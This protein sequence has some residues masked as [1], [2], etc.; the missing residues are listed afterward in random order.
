MAGRWSQ[1]SE[2]F[3]Y[4][5]LHEKRFQELCNALL[6]RENPSVT[7]FPVGQR[8]GGRDAVLAKGA[9]PDVIYQVKWAKQPP[10][11]PVGWLIAA[12]RGESANIERLV[13][14]G[15]RSYV[16]MTC[17]PGTAAP[18]SGSM[19]RLDLE[20]ARCSEQFGIP[21][22]CL[23]R[24]DIDARVE[25]APNELVW[26]YAEMLAGHEAVRYVIEA[27]KITGEDQKLRR[28]LLN[29]I[30]TQWEEDAKIKFR[31]VELDTYNLSD[32]YVDVEAVRTVA[33]RS[34]GSEVP[35]ML[36]RPKDVVSLGGAAEYLLSPEHPLTLV[37]GEPGQGKSTLAQ[38]LCQLHRAS[39]LRDGSY[40]AG[41]GEIPRVESP[42]LPLRVD[43]RDYAR[44]CGGE[45][46]F[47]EDEPVPSRRRR[48]RQHPTL[49]KFLAYLLTARG[50]G[51]EVGVEVVSDVLERFPMLIVLDGLDEVAH[52]ETRAHVSKEIGL[53]AARLN[54]SANV[55]QVIVTTR[56]NASGLAEPSPERFETI[57]LVPLSPALR[58]EYLRKWADARGLRGA[59]RRAVET[60]FQQR[61]IEPHI[62][63]LADNPMQLTILLYL[64]QK[65]GESVPDGRTQLFTA[66]MET[67]LDRESE[68][69]PLV[70]EHR[71]D[72]VEVT[73]FLG[74]H[75]QASAEID[76]SAGRASTRAIRKAILTYLHDAEKDTALVDDLFTAVT[77][78]VW[79]LSSKVQG[80]FE[81]DVQTMREYFAA[82]YLWGF[83]G[84]DLRN[85]DKSAILGELV[86]RPYWLNTARFFAG[87]A[88]PNELAGLVDVLADE[89]EKVDRPNQVR[90][91]AWTLL[92]DG[93]FDRQTRAHK[94]AARLFTDDL[95]VRLM[96]NG[97]QWAARTAWTGT[98]GS[99]RDRGPDH[100]IALLEE[101]I[102]RA[103]DEPMNRDRIGLIQ[104]LGGDPTSWWPREMSASVG[105]DLELAWLRCGAPLG[106]GGQ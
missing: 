54:V 4:E 23:W 15:A 12:I 71:E 34:A 10:Q 28:I 92:S 87:F 88:H 22:R 65:R 33:A 93:V 103:P 51:A 27:D 57:A 3:L 62:A 47:A 97:L 99:T 13:S 98:E 7:C 70:H 69:S 20:L 26:S 50:A 85:F 89:F 14:E 105:S 64:I 77:D 2:R 90:A 59:A 8:D 63:Q 53:L 79:A 102:K 61:A 5:R 21:M 104:D 78:R 68:K 38:Y 66:Y 44:W 75:L 35:T 96:Q 45:E 30:A 19:D 72:L 73:S 82:A 32:L 91:A 48:R 6:V 29:V 86:R 101:T 106:Q 37:R 80:T 100:L 16:L 49:E 74:W 31:Q 40:P 52:R 60:T 95:S 81:F 76:Q 55:P 11:N 94:R 56:P 24:A 39:F 17:V 41:A 84:A 58:T 67:F 46:P 36:V 18:G 9:K 83:A 25:Q 43:L 1:N 42:R